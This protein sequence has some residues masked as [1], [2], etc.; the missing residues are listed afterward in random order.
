MWGAIPWILLEND[1]L[2][3]NKKAINNYKQ[4]ATQRKRK[5]SNEER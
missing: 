3:N 5:I 4:T 1:R 2:V